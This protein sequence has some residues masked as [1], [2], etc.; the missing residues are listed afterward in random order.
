MDGMKWRGG[1]KKRSA[2]I[3]RKTKETDIALSLTIDGSGKSRIK[4]GIPFLDHMLTLFAKHGLFDLEI[5][6]KGDLDVDIHHTNE[7]IGICLGEAIKKA[8]KDKKGIKRFGVGYVPMEEALAKVVL[9]LSGRYNMS[10]PIK[11]KSPGTKVEGYSL[12]DTE[13]FLKA[14]SREAGI[15]L[16]VNLESGSD[17]HH[18]IEAVFKAL[19]KALDEAT[20]VDPRSK[21]IPSTKGKL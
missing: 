10:F 4:T 11:M 1:M 14:M 15:N 3:K 21:G 19:G 13:H 9:D 20:M 12:D 5:K 2:K 8:L 16:N 17:M 7:D 18:I 6:A